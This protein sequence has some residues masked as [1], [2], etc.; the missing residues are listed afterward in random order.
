MLKPRRVADYEHERENEL[1]EARKHQAETMIKVKKQEANVKK[2]ERAVEEKQPDLVTLETQIAHSEKK[3]RNTQAIFE[4]VERDHKRQSE[5]LEILET[6]RAQINE[7][8]EE[9]KE[10]QRQRN[11]KAGKALSADDLAEYRKL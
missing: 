7:R 8:M 1:K 3:G 2:A 10:R 11:V 6:G 9:A 4:Q 5:E